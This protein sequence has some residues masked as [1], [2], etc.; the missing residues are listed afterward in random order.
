MRLLS[1]V[2]EVLSDLV[3]PVVAKYR[4]AGILTWLLIHQIEADVLEEALSRGK[5][6]AMTINMIRSHEAFRYPKDDRPA[7]FVGHDVIP[8]VFDTIEDAWNRLH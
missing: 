1:N 2:D 4:E 7:S 6:S 3:P 5:L 8:M